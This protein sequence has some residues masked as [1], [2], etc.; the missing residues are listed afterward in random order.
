MRIQKSGAAI[1]YV[2]DV[3]VT[4]LQCTSRVFP[5]FVE[6]H[7]SLSM[8]KYFYKHFRPQYPDFAL[9]LI[10]MLVFVRLAVRAVPLTFGWVAEWNRA[11]RQVCAGPTGIHSRADRQRAVQGKSVSVRVAIGGRRLLKKKQNRTREKID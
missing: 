2:P 7:K 11:Q 8:K 4:H 1:L 9:T 10:G 6:W 5:L 3:S